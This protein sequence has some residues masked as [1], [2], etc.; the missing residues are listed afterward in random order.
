MGI[1][2]GALVV[3]LA[4][5]GCSLTGGKWVARVNGQAISQS[6]FDQRVAASEALYKTQGM[7]FTSA[8]GKQ[9][10]AQLKNN[11]LQR[12][13]EGDVISQE[14]RKLGLSTNDSQVKQ[15]EAGLKQ[16]FGTE[17]KF[18]DALKQQGMTEQELLDFLALYQ[19]VSTGVKVSASDVQNYFNAHK[20]QYGHPEE[21]EARHILVKTKAEAEQI[22][23]E[24]NKGANFAQLAK[25]KSTDPG[26]KDKGG[27]LG[28]FTQNQMD[29]AF[30]KAAFSQKVGTW[31]QTPV[32]SSY[33]YHIILVEAHKPAVT[34]DFNAVKA[35]VEQDAL[36]S[37][38]DAKFQSYMDALM[39]KATIKYAHGFEPTAAPS[40][41]TPAPAQ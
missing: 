12:M 16:N 40:A 13:V 35:Q 4:T 39:K 1:V 41:P 17:A 10:E 9:A 6:D 21:V 26:S 38:K 5:A 2:A 19:K 31:S 37:A 18:Q 3:L 11:I 22:I 14:V 32:K 20:S 23:A 7:D 36:T 8:Q 25:E 33:G 27:E 29:P 15:Q 30:A 28:F 34:P 24:L